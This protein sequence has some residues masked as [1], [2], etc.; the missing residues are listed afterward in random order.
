MLLLRSF[1]GHLVKKRLL[2]YSLKMT[3]QLDYLAL[4]ENKE[5][6]SQYLYIILF[7]ITWGVVK[8]KSIVAV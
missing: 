7:R 3:L 8:K 5:E 6:Y 2:S 4:W 1:V